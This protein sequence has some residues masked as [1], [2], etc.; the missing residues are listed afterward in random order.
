[1]KED[2]CQIMTACRHMRRTILKMG[3]SA[4]LSGAHMGGSL[5]LVEIMAV[6]YLRVMQTRGDSFSSANA[7][8]LILSKGHG[9]MAQY[10]VLY[11]CGILSD[12][13]LKTFKHDGS[14]L[15]AH[16][17]ADLRLGEWFA[18]GSLGQGLSLGLGMAL[19]LR[20]RNS[21]ARVFVVLGDGECDEG[22]VWEAAMAASAYQADNLVVIVDRN[23]LQYDGKTEEIM[24]LEDMQAKWRAFGWQCLSVSGHDP[25]AL[26]NSI[27]EPV[28]GPM[29]VI[30]DTVKGKGISFM[31]NV[32]SWHS[33]FVSDEV[34]AKALA[35]LG[36]E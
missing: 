17:H 2:V 20:K 9:V 32:P 27:T 34:Y 23:R 13:D 29:A 18:S 21:P 35:E 7:D 14:A 36:S 12:D 22:Q 5:S 30:A 3:H 4:G 6:L 1:M 25:Q 15:S 10:A 26:I 28:K 8:R 33:G 24:P 16:P 31:E 11:E 19:A